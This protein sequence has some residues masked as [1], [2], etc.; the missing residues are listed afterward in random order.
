MT[1]A[2]MLRSAALCVC[3]GTSLFLLVPRAAA[4]SDLT[5]SERLAAMNDYVWHHVSCGSEGCQSGPIDE[6]LVEPWDD[7]PKACQRRVACGDRW[8]VRADYLMWWVQGNRVPPLV[9]AS[10]L[11]TPRDQAGVFGESGTSVL[12]GGRQIDDDLRHGVRVTL[13]RWLGDSQ[14]WGLEGHYFYLGDAGDG[15]SASTPDAPI[16]ARPV[17]DSQ[18]GAASAL[19]VAFPD[20]VAG[21]IVVD[22]SSDVHS[23]GGL[24]RR[25]WL[26]G[27]YGQVAL[28]GGYRYFRLRERLAI[29][30]TSVWV[31]E[32]EPSL[33]GTETQIQDVFAVQNDFHGVDLG[34]TAE[35]Q[36][37]RWSLDVLT[38]L[39]IG[40]VRQQLDIGGQTRTSTLGGATLG[41]DSGLLAQASNSGSY[42]DTQFA[43][44]PE[45][46]ANVGYSVSPS[47][48][49]HAGYSLMWLT[50]ALRTGDQIDVAT[51]G[52]GASPQALRETTSVCVQGVSVGGEWRR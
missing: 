36:R 42:R 51:V 39:G 5:I 43:F 34:L 15:Y 41:Q 45:L 21:Q 7:L 19:L 25:N 40:G 33:F 29:D 1:A 27:S 52:A 46:G 4:D 2:R 37:G 9:T 16:L 6:E 13:G 28:L 44:L 48:S 26:R 47:L 17:F 8:Y 50:D 31:D 3:V 18:L 38:K 32:S 22:T 20:A 14:D 11:G 24:L 35:M 49:F 10:P 30:G 12:S 23:A